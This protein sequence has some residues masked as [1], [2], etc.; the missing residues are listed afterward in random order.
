MEI[1]PKWLPLANILF[2]G[3]LAVEKWRTRKEIDA[4]VVNGK[5]AS[6]QKEIAELHR[7]ASDFGS[8]QQTRV[9]EMSSR[10]AVVESR[11]NDACADI[12]NI[13]EDIKPMMRRR[14]GRE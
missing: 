3:I 10:M 13:R 14:P 5:I 2:L 1:D 12:E 8:Q 9:G 11:L 7:K 6:M 4:A